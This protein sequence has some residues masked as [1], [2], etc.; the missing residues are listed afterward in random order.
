MANTNLNYWHTA[1]NEKKDT[2]VEHFQSLLKR[3]I[4]SVFLL[5]MEN[6]EIVGIVS[7]NCWTWFSFITLCSSDRQAGYVWQ[8]R[9]NLK[10]FSGVLSHRT[11]AWQLEMVLKQNLA[12]MVYL[13]TLVK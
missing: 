9:L 6:N 4:I 12:P 8:K 2:F 5:F 7:I 10:L 13:I 11:C 3:T 1:K